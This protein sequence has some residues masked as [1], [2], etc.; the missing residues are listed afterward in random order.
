MP[1]FAAIC[2]LGLVVG[3]SASA[4]Q[5]RHSPASA[6]VKQLV[7][8]L[9]SSDAHAAYRLLADKTRKQIPYAEFAR[10]WKQY[11]PER[12][13]KAKALEDVLKEDPDLGE[14]SRVVY[15]DGKSVMLLRQ[16]G[17]WKLES[18]LVAENRAGSAREAVRIFAE[19]MANRNFDAVMRI[20]T[21]RRRKAISRQVDA[22]VTS[23]ITQV[24]RPGMTVT[25]VGKDR[26]ELY[27]EAKGKRYKIV[28]LREGDEWRI[29]DI[30]LRGAPPAK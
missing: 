6:G 16:R 1:R 10:N 26:A 25:K 28:L 19:S 7:A 27:W 22:F 20:L 24:S 12:E 21:G 18:A 14:R 17:N 4:K 15:P 30:H 3:C 2:A 5:V 13:H 8:A 29:D 23:L 9:R 11:K